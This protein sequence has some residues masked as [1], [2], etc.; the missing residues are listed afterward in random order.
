M[1]CV[2]RQA[3]ESGDQMPS[4]TDAVAALRRYLEEN[5]PAMT[6]HVYVSNDGFEDDE[7]YLP[8]WGAREALVDHLLGYGHMD[9]RVLFV[10]RHT[11]E[12]IEDSM[13]AAFD[14][15]NAMRKVK[16]GQP[17]APGPPPRAKPSL[18]T[19]IRDQR[20][21][22]VMPPSAPPSW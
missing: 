22:V 7:H 17:V 9:S 10:D 21:D 15:V 5:P 14:K 11:G 4:F 20:P 16:D 2:R 19:K 3:P 13:P 8:I 12:V 6:G 1:A 18:S